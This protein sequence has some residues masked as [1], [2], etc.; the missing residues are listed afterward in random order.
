MSHYNHFQTPNSARYYSQQSSQDMPSPAGGHGRPSTAVPSPMAQ[1]TEPP[2]LHPAIGPQRYIA[3]LPGP[4]Q[5]A[6]Q[7]QI[8]SFHLPSL[9]SLSGL[10]RTATSAPG[11]PQ[12][13]TPPVT[14][15]IGG[16]PAGDSEIQII[17]KSLGQHGSKKKA[18]AASATEP[19]K[20]RH[21]SLSDTEDQPAPTQP[22][23]RGKTATTNATSNQP[24][25]SSQPKVKLSNNGGRQPGARGY[26]KVE[27]VM[28]T[29]LMRKKLPTGTLG[30][31]AVHRAYNQWA[32]KKNYSERQLSG[33]KAKWG[34]LVSTKKPT[35]NAKVPREVRE[36]KE[37]DKLISRKAEVRALNDEAEECSGSGKSGELDTDTV[38]GLSSDD[39][40]ENESSESGG[41]TDDEN[42]SGKQRMPSNS[43]KEQIKRTIIDERKGKGSTAGVLNRIAAVFDPETMAT[44]S[45]ARGK[46]A[47]E[48]SGPTPRAEHRPAESA[49]ST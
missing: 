21:V 26:S 7:A 41:A 48:I 11:A 20:K 47:V 46:F 27:L 22:A 35:G 17:E 40:L 38:S 45:T 29:K 6:H 31:S 5:S 39:D 15:A 34:A 25:K 13:P 28:L 32:A 8:R 30:W 2:R 14:Q 19:A 23:K 37:I 24:K 43:T 33:L 12:T 49:S 4:G 16:T 1:A 9:P 18:T 44:K 10:S 42:Q 36:A 3:P